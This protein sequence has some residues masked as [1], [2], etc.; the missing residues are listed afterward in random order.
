M[1]KLIV[2]GLGIALTGFIYWFFFGKRDEATEAKTEWNIRVSG[3]YQP[4]TITIPRGK[5]ATLTFTRE[6]PNSCLEDI[7][8]E[9]FKIKRFLPLNEPVT[10][11]LSPG[12]AGTFE[13]HCGMNMFHGR[14][15]VS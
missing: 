1:D 2:T 4:S 7:V 14:I 12:S 11:T 9:K 6:D 3:G 5:R 15:I 8:I 13:M 10:V